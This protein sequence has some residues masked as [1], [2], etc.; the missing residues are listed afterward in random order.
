M[1]YLDAALSKRVEILQS[2]SP[3]VHAEIRAMLRSSSTL[4]ET[5]AY[6]LAADRLVLGSLRRAKA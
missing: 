1:H 3:R 5:Q 6:E 4:S 2:R